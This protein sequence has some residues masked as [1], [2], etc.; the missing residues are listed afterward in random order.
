VKTYTSAFFWWRPAGAPLW[1]AFETTACPAAVVSEPQGEALG[2]S[3]DGL[4]YYTVS[5]GVHQP[6]HYFTL[7]LN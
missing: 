4:G 1:E 2:F 7:T 6:I 3:A 5:E